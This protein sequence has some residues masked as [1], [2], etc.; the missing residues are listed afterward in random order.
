LIAGAELLLMINAIRRRFVW[1]RQARDF[2]LLMRWFLFIFA[3]TIGHYRRRPLI[4]M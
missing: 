4:S 3:F 2:I 1:R